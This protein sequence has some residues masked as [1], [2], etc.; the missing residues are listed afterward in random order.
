[1]A[2]IHLR[3]ISSSS[4]LL[5]WTS[6]SSSQSLQQL[7]QT[8]TN[9]DSWRSSATDLYAPR[10]RTCSVQKSPST[11]VP[12]RSVGGVLQSSS[13]QLTACSAHG[14]ASN[15]LRPLAI[16]LLTLPAFIR[17]RQL[18]APDDLL[19]PV[20][21]GTTRWKRERGEKRKAGIN[22]KLYWQ[23]AFE[24]SSERKSP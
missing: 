9:M 2:T 5:S 8:N 7:S 1:M 11:R 20:Y 14:A 18:M 17:L 10:C 15:C 4:S 22:A 6:L 19:C 12:S 13:A 23:V 3:P 16:L 21:A 24:S